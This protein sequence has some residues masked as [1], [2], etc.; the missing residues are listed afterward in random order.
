[1]DR[2]VFAYRKITI[3]KKKIIVFCFLTIRC[4][5]QGFFFH[6]L[7]LAKGMKGS[8]KEERQTTHNS[9]G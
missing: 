1:M 4:K 5:K 6:A 9:L 7:I 8:I 2:H 3:S